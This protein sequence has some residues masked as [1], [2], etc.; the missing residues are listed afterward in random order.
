MS[1]LGFQAAHLL[2]ELFQQRGRSRNCA[3]TEAKSQAT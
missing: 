3:I 2:S 1:R